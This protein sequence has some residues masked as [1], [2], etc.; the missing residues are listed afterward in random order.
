M[1]FV[2][3]SL[4]GLPWALGLAGCSPGPSTSSS[5]HWLS[6]EEDADCSVWGEGVSCG[7]EGLCVRG[8]E[9]M[10]THQLLAEEFDG[11][12]DPVTFGYEEGAS[13]RNGDAEFYTA[14]AE[15]VFTDEGALVLRA[16]AESYEGSEYTSGSVTTQ[17]RFSFTHGVVEARI[18]APDG[19][20]TGPAFWLM[21]ESPGPA[22]F[23]CPDPTD[24][25]SCLEAQWPVWGDIVV[26]TTRSESPTHVIQSSSYGTFDDA[27][28][29]VVRGEQGG[30]TILSDSVASGYHD[31]AVVWGPRR[32]DWYYDG[33]KTQTFD[34]SVAYA[35]DGVNPFDRPFHIKL[36]LAVGGLAQAPDPAAYPQEMRVA[37]LRVTQFE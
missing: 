22:E 35:P 15:N 20:G 1:R 26:M 17:G 32:I 27:L 2:R 5:S 24:Q 13:V 19:V 28:G 29:A 7:A 25:A 9:A 16:L 6:C 12:L 30:T 3:I 18:W 21:P 36:N 14:R 8:G 23:Y 31:Y 37:H 4:L 10:A 33:K 11:P 34:T